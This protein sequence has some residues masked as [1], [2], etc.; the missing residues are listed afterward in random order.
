[1]GVVRLFTLYRCWING[2]KLFE[3]ICRV[4]YGVGD[5]R[6]S[7]LLRGLCA[8]SDLW[9]LSVLLRG[10]CAVSDRMH[11]PNIKILQ[12]IQEINRQSLKIGLCHYL[13][14]PSNFTILLS[15]LTLNGI[16]VPLKTAAVAQSV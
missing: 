9:I 6:V 12:F 10:L 16:L 1:V 14:H 3:F 7:V 11:C 2:S 13:S 8:V 15:H 4:C 5:L